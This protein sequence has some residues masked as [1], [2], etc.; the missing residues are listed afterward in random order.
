MKAAAVSGGHRLK[1]LLGWIVRGQLGAHLRNW[2]RLRARARRL[3]ASGAFDA[4]WYRS[5][6]PDVAASGEDPALHYL[7][8]GAA[9]GRAAMPGGVVALPCLPVN[10]TNYADWVVAYEGAGAECSCSGLATL[11]PRV[12]VVLLG[13]AEVSVDADILLFLPDGVR[14]APIALEAIARAFADAPE[15]ALVYTD[16]D[17]VDA[18]GRRFAP[19]FKPDWD[20]DWMAARDL[21]D[22]TGA[23]RRWVIDQIGLAEARGLAASGELGRRAVSMVEAGEIRHIPAVLF[24]VGI[25]VP[26]WP[27]LTRPSSRRGLHGVTGG[28]RAAGTKRIAGSSPAMTGEGG[29]GLTVGGGA[30]ITGEVGAPSPLVTVI[31]PT[32]DR[33][34]LLER[35]ADGVLHGTDYAPLELLIVDND[36]RQHR[37]LRMLRRLC[38]DPR[39]RVLPFPGAFNWSA[40]NNAAVRVARGEVIVLLNNDV[41]VLDPGWLRHMVS[42]ALRSD[43]GVVGARLL[44][45][46]GTVQH[47]GITLGPGGM[48]EHVLHRATGDARGYQDML[49]VTRTVAAVTGACMAM[50]RAVFDAVGGFEEVHLGVSYNDVDFCLRVRAKGWRV[51]CTPLAEL[52]HH[53]A[54]SRGPDAT[55]AQLDRVRSERTYLLASWGAA[56]ERDPYLGPNLTTIGGDPVLAR[57]PRTA[58]VTTACGSR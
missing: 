48:A 9:E 45:P 24:H 30:A 55:A 46:D 34:R 56:A 18:R 43:T 8:R 29:P 2:W 5:A 11:L 39:V 33:A 28:T 26:S 40:M 31:V 4:G 35:C 36:S 12:G 41:E 25:P 52:R 1:H 47:A 58:D 54:M 20:P 7:R 15:V 37:T 57:P 38:L 21:I 27:D 19:W 32:R 13:G 23:Y 42:L 53:E 44:F 17:Q 10:D 14:L 49:A 50:R 22:V 6:Y 3:L 16:E 51:V